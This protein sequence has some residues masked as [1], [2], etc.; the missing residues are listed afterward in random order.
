[1]KKRYTVIEAHGAQ[2]CAVEGK[3]GREWRTLGEYD[4]LE[5]ALSVHPTARNRH[6]EAWQQSQRH[7]STSRFFYVND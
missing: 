2:I 5:E 1:V 6:S 3:Y 4:S 7:D